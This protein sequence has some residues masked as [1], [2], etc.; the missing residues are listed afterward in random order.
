MMDIRKKISRLSHFLDRLCLT[1]AVAFFVLMLALVALQVV[2]RYLFRIAPV[3]T[4]EAARYCMVWGGLLGATVAYKRLRDPRLTA[5]PKGE[6]SL[7]VLT[8]K[9]LRGIGAIIFLGP[10]LFYSN[11]F[12]ARHW[13]RTSEAMDFSTFWVAIAVPI[14]ITVIFI[15]LLAELAGKQEALLSPQEK[16][17]WDSD[18]PRTQLRDPAA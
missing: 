5:P 6:G 10:V 14:A 15:H 2:G 16:P 4:E 18:D 17:R 8:A 3:W 7:W 9:Y 13:D 11:R 1:G 12:L